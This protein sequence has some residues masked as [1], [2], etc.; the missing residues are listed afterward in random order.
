MEG[1]TRER[2]QEGLISAF[3]GNEV[4]EPEL[5][6]CNSGFEALLK[7]TIHVLST[8][9]QEVMEVEE[10]WDFD[11]RNVECAIEA[12]D[13]GGSVS[14]AGDLQEGFFALFTLGGLY[15]RNVLKSGPFETLRSW[16]ESSCHL[17]VPQ[18][19]AQDLN[20]FFA[21]CRGLEAM[22]ENCVSTCIKTRASELCKP[23]MDTM[24][25]LYDTID[26]G[27][28]EAWRHIQRLT[29]ADLCDPRI[30]SPLRLWWM[31]SYK[32]IVWASEGPKHVWQ[33]QMG[34]LHRDDG[35]AVELG[36]AQEG[37]F[38]HGDLV[39]KH[40]IME[41]PSLDEVAKVRNFFIEYREIGPYRAQ[42]VIA[43]ILQARNDEGRGKRSP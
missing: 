20:V 42:S 30:K 26:D 15:S 18:A 28:Q 14:D 21:N 2:F 13:S 4:S 12:I 33:D 10:Q 34:R 1:N 17:M 29:P 39:P 27:L 19:P 43:D 3:Q 31:Y 38:W 32:N 24:V 7:A 35:P 9:M 40:W 37:Y 22:V 11:T 36:E 8:E 16:L 5:V 23:D 6:F 41:G 25:D